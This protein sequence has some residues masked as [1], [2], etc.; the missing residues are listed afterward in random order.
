MSGYITGVF[1]IRPHLLTIIILWRFFHPMV[2]V[3]ISILT[4]FI[5]TVK[6]YASN[7]GIEALGI[8]GLV[9]MLKISTEYFKNRYDTDW[10]ALQVVSKARR[11]S[12][13]MSLEWEP[14]AFLAR[15]MLAGQG[16]K[17]IGSS[18][19][20]L[21]GIDIIA[22]KDGKRS[23]FRFGRSTAEVI[24][25]REIR[26]LMIKAQQFKA[27]AGFIVTP[28]DVSSSAERC[29]KNM[30]VTIVK[31]SELKMWFNQYAGGK[32]FVNSSNDQKNSDLSMSSF[33]SSDNETLAA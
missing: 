21:S 30:P 2:S 15:H 33:S 3:L 14:Y 20:D 26:N 5:A 22:E 19:N 27:S 24:Y 6:A 17:I 29:Q 4:D 25:E 13:I 1:V 16:Y 18:V 31:S 11:L 8:I 32:L 7:F 28:G 23:L 12:E 10:G 9:I